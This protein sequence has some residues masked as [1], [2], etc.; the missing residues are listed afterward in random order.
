MDVVWVETCTVVGRCR[1]TNELNEEIASVTQSGVEASIP[2]FRNG[3]TASPAGSST[4]RSIVLSV[5]IRIS[6][7]IAFTV[8]ISRRPALNGP[9]ET[10]P[11]VQFYPLIRPRRRVPA[12]SQMPPPGCGADSES[13][14]A[15]RLVADQQAARHRVD[16]HLPHRIPLRTRQP[17]TQPSRNM[18]DYLRTLN[19]WCELE[20]GGCVCR[21]ERFWVSALAASGS[22][23][24]CAPLP[25]CLLS[26]RTSATMSSKCPPASA[27]VPRIA[28]PAFDSLPAGGN[29]SAAV[30][31]CS[32]IVVVSAVSIRLFLTGL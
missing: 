11:P 19:H 29:F 30:S 10:P 5:A 2:G 1:L 14:R 23:A 9:P 3:Q 17:H 12:V 8:S 15:I 18:V 24:R 16:L 20:P 31:G 25:A 26:A 22:A 32:A 4:L 21:R 13:G 7:S 28:L 27:T 6:L